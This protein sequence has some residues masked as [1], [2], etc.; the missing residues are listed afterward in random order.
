MNEMIEPQTFAQRREQIL[1]EIA[2]AAKAVGRNKDDIILVAA[3]KTQPNE[4]IEEAIA[5]GQL[6]FGENRV[7]EGQ[8]HFENRDKSSLELRM[9]GPVQS[10]KAEEAVALFDVI[11]TLDR[12]SLAQAIAKAQNKLGKK[13]KLLVQVNIGDEEQKSGIEV[14]ELPQFLDLCK[15]KYELEIS[16]L[17]CV[18]PADEPAGPYFALLQKLAKR[19]NLK[20]LSMGM[21]GDFKIAIQFGATH[22]RIGTALFG[23]RN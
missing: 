22:I 13:I 11:E 2:K 12:E 9:I 21:S 14:K 1:E 23:A 5:S 3:C 19:H 6:V 10:K 7:H 8:G 4:I 20:E 18:P 15:N 17:M 16:G